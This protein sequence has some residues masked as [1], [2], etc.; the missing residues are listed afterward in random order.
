MGLIRHYQ[1]D[2]A[3]GVLFKRK[4]FKPK[5]LA[6]FRNININKTILPTVRL[7]DVRV[8]LLA[9]LTFKL[10]PCVRYQMRP[11]LFL[12]HFLFKPVL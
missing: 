2:H 5:E 9:D 11:F 3:R 1:V 12:L 10:F 4:R 8:W 7:E 6:I